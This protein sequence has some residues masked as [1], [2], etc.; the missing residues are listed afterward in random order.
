MRGLSRQGCCDLLVAAACLTSEAFAGFL[1]PDEECVTSEYTMSPEGLSALQVD[2]DPGAAA[3]LTYESHP[4]S[5][6]RDILISVSADGLTG[7]AIAVG[8]EETTE[9]GVKTISIPGLHQFQEETAQDADV[10]GSSS[11][12]LKGL[13]LLPVLCGAF[14]YLHKRSGRQGVLVSAAFLGLG[15]VLALCPAGGKTTMA[16]SVPDTYCMLPR[17]PGTVQLKDCSSAPQ[18]FPIVDTHTHA[19][20]NCYKFSD[21][22]QDLSACPPTPGK[23]A[24]YIPAGVLPF[25]QL[26]EKWYSQNITYGVL[27][28]PSFMGVN[29][30]YIVQQ[31][32]KYPRLRGVIMVTNADGTLNTDAV[33]PS[34]LESMHEAGVRGIRLN[35]LKKPEDDMA[36]LN[37]AMNAETGEQGFR[38]LWAFIKQHDWHVEAQQDSEGW[39]HLIDTL[40]GK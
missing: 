35:L 34:L 11:T 27:V 5:V 38:E 24:R 32:E 26:Q 31:L 3:S 33:E 1:S 17:P 19:W 13:L 16:V 10:V 23:K 20:E 25:P 39:V 6:S 30:T 28:Q 40:V 29:N 2:I 9:A 14:L 12:G 21:T 7:A 15:G 8:V 36:R 4:S 18:K 22:D 37:A